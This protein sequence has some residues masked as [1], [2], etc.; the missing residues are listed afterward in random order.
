MNQYVKIAFGIGLTILLLTL[1]WKFDFFKSQ[2]AK[3]SEALGQGGGGL[4]TDSLIT[5]KVLEDYKKAYGNKKPTAS[6]IFS[7]PKKWQEFYFQIL[8]SSGVIN[9]DENAV[10]NVFRSLKSKTDI[11]G[12]AIFFQGVKKEGLFDY[13]SKYL[14]SEEVAKVAQIIKDKKTI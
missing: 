3:D 12:F 5:K 14:D 13:I 4:D 8:G 9:D 11:K 2:D 10:Y 6:E 7:S 1:L